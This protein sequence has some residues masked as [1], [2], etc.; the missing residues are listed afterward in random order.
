MRVAIAAD[1]NGVDLK[2]HLTT[3]LNEHGHEVDDRGSHD[4]DVVDYP[5]LCADV[6]R[7]VVSGAA[8]TGLVL[9]GSGQGEVIACNKINGV[10]AGLCHTEFATQISRGH[11]DANVM[12]VGAKVVDTESAE[13]LLA[14]W[15]DTP[16]KGGRHQVRV[17]QIAA[18]ES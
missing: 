5:A 16:F 14:L 10:R 8:D 7:L 2:A 17:D 6:G 9:G 11:N 4:H 12:V 1:H 15:F 3:W 18:L 13:R